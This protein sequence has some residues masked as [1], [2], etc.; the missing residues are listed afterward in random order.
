MHPPYPDLPPPETF[1]NPLLVWQRGRCSFA[2]GGDGLRL[3]RQDVPQRVWSQR[4][5]SQAHE[6]V[7]PVTAKKEKELGRPNEIAYE[8]EAAN[9][10]NLIGFVDH[11]LSGITPPSSSNFALTNWI[12]ITFEGDCI[13]RHVL[14]QNLSFVQQISLADEQLQAT[15]ASVAALKKL[16]KSVKFHAVLC[17]GAVVWLP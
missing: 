2:I 12:P 14:V 4:G 8:K 3:R 10:V 7:R 13:E 5:D 17:I 1:I 9:W 15:E 11:L 6:V 16:G